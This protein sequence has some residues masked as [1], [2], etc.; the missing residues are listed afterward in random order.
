MQTKDI[1]PQ[2]AHLD[3]DEHL[4]EGRCQCLCLACTTRDG[5]C[6][7]P[8]CDCEEPGDHGAW[9]WEA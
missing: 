9:V 2:A 4:P 3:D 5:R 8:E 1:S 6:V 7:C